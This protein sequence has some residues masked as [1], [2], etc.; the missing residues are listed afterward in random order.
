[1][2]NHYVYW[3]HDR[4]GVLLY[5]GCTSQPLARYAQHM[6]KP[7][8]RKRGWFNQFLT[9]WRFRGPLPKADAYELES[10]EIAEKLPIFNVVGISPNPSSGR[11]Q[12]VADY[13]HSHGRIYPQFPIRPTRPPQE[14]EL[15]DEE[16]ELIMVN[17]L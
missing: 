6:S 5:V 10:A 14:P 12:V 4:D 16:S 7:E 13:F 15:F 9:R 1:M 11:R 17:G 8:D 3:V 2:R